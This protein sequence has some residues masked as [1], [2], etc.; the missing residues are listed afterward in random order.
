MTTRSF[1]KIF[2]LTSRTGQEESRQ[3]LFHN[4]TELS[5]EHFEEHNTEDAVLYNENSNSTQTSGTSKDLLPT[6]VCMYIHGILI[7]TLFF[8]A[9]TR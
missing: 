2:K 8:I 3:M 4:A 6:N 1:I 5:I 9:I 7:T